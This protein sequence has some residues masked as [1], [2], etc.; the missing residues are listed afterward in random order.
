MLARVR[1][2]LLL[3]ETL[4]SLEQWSLSTLAG[5][6]E[7]SSW[8][9]A[10]TAAADSDVLLTK[11]ILLFSIRDRVWCECVVGNAMF[12]CVWMSSDII[13]ARLSPTIMMMTLSPPPLLL[14]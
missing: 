9:P 3:W 5:D 1:T 13:I 14:I 2:G 10:P 7:L 8:A 12:V 6:I 4:L 11:T